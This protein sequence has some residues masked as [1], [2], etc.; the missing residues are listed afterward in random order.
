MSVPPGQSKLDVPLTFRPTDPLGAW[1]AKVAVDGQVALD[2]DFF[3]VAPTPPPK[4]GLKSLA[5]RAPGSA[6]PP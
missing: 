5:P 2:W 3:V 6:P 4:V 1:H